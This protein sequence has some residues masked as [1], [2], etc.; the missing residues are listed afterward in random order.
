MQRSTFF[1]KSYVKY[2]FIHWQFDDF[3]NIKELPHP[4]KLRTYTKIDTTIG[5]NLHNFFKKLLEIVK[6]MP[7]L[8]NRVPNIYTKIARRLLFDFK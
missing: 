1:R 3:L 5:S 2:T 8:T 7:Q 4:E 6:K